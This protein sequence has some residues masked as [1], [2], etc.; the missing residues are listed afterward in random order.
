MLVKFKLYE[1]KDLGSKSYAEQRCHT[2]NNESTGKPLSG[3]LPRVCWAS[4]EPK[5]KRKDL[6]PSLESEA[7]KRQLAKDVWSG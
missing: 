1:P 7:S 6:T 3:L 4:F 5:N 2:N